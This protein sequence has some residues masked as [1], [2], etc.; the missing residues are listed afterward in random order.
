MQTRPGQASAHLPIAQ[1]NVFAFN[2]YDRFPNCTHHF[3]GHKT[4]VSCFYHPHIRK[5]D[6]I[7]LFIFCLI[8]S[9][10]SIL[11][12]PSHTQTHTRGGSVFGTWEI[13][14][15]H[16]PYFILRYIYIAIAI[17]ET[18]YLCETFIVLESLDRRRQCVIK[19]FRFFFFIS[20]IIN[21]SFA[22]LLATAVSRECIFCKDLCN[23]FVQA[24][25]LII[26][27]LFFILLRTWNDIPYRC[28]ARQRDELR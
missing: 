5:T 28:V 20:S 21:I 10:W 2:L 12:S 11:S 16:T 9:H 25:A 1:Q 23:R 26:F 24:D 4:I 18:F 14:F 8:S 22:R 27:F 13:V 15:S 19:K 6:M 3:H 7:L 17:L